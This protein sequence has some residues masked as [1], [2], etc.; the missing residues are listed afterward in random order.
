MH[1]EQEGRPPNP[2]FFLQEHHKPAHPE[3]WNSLAVYLRS[4]LS[5]YVLLEIQKINLYEFPLKPIKRVVVPKQEAEQEPL[6]DATYSE[7]TYRLFDANY[8]Q[9]SNPEVKSDPLDHY[10]TIGA[11]EG[12]FPNLLFDPDYYLS[13]QKEEVPI[14]PLK[15]Y[16]LSGKEGRSPHPLFNDNYY[17]EQTSKLDIPEGVSLLE[18]F[19]IKGSKAGLSPCK[20]FS[21]SYYLSENT[22]VRQ[23]KISP[24]FHYLLHGEQENRKPSA[25]F[26]P[27][28]W[29]KPFPL[30]EKEH[31]LFQYLGKLGLQ[32]RGIKLRP[33]SA[34]ARFQRGIKEMDP[35]KPVLIAITH[36]ASRTGAP[37]IILKLAE[38]FKAFF[39]LN[40]VC[41]L[42]DGGEL[43]V[44]FENMGPSYLVQDY[45]R[46]KESILKP[47]ANTV[48][49]A[50][51]DF[52]VIGAL[53]NSAESREWLPYLKYRKIPTIS[54]V[55]EMAN[56]YKP[57]SFQRIAENTDKVV[58]PSQIVRKLAI[59]NAPF[60]NNKII[61]RGQGL[62]K[63]KIL[64][65]DK[66]EAKKL[67]REELDLP[68]KS[69]I[70]L[71][72]GSLSGRKGPDLFVQ[73]GLLALPK[74][75]EDVYFVWLGGGH[76]HLQDISYWLEIDLKKKGLD[77]RIQF[78]GERKVTEH[79]FV[80][81]DIFY[82][83]SRA[84]PFPCVVHEAM[85]ARTPIVGYEDAG[86][87]S[88]AL[89]GN[90]GKLVP[91][92][93]L[94]KAAEVICEWVESPEKGLYFASNAFER[95]NQHY[96]YSD[97]TKDLAVQLSELV[98]EYPE[99]SQSPIAESFLEK[100]SSSKP[101]DLSSGKKNSSKSY[102][103]CSQL[104]N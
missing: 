87:F 79:F 94:S 65:M 73:T 10:L 68:L 11:K 14:E 28:F 44:D 45:Y 25:E 83:T 37:L 52:T 43:E 15:H 88:E 8:Y 97:Y 20:S 62:L 31:R 55:H 84:D 72:C 51:S 99:L 77:H 35:I 103:Y 100:V 66:E 16:V 69:K 6:E 61:V 19:L 26:D 81:S 78:I 57:K 13:A 48:L 29:L 85:A 18:H 54:L 102:F 86:G 101:E 64:G 9:F 71:G 67:L 34:I 80:G 76:R 70:V 82:L 92:A 24:F 40:I 90:S 27:S 53:V 104:A 23:K 30:N 47:Q 59:E 50:L 21:P 12:R 60:E 5:F 96:H 75:P 41:I 1:G 89:A 63:P 46:W 93:D 33:I 7:N 2:E 58:F 95:V 36:D 42:C 56:L 49:D 38:Q 98:L 3:H 17:L 74:L 91:Y 39:D 32:H 22:D 4:K